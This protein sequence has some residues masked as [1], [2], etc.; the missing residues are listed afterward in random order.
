[1]FL[2]QV[3]PIQRAVVGLDRGQGGALADG[4]VRWGLQQRPPGV[5]DRGGLLGAAGPA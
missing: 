1:L 5:L 4:E 2:E 3:G